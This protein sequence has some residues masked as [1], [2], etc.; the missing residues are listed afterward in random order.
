M[1]DPW[2]P[3][4]AAAMQRYVHGDWGISN[5]VVDPDSPTTVLTVVD[6][7]DSHIGDPAE[8]FRWQVLAGPQSLEYSAMRT[9]Y[10]TAGRTLG[11]RAAERLALAGAELCLDV[12]RWDVPGDRVAGFQERSLRTLEEFLAGQLP[13]PP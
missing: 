5:V 4:P 2:I 13:E 11:P 7:E 3:L 10:G 8:D 1:V 12:L 9:G 6:F